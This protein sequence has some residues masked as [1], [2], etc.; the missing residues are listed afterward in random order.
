MASITAVIGANTTVSANVLSNTS[1]VVRSS[2]Q[3]LSAVVTA[4][5]VTT[6]K[7]T[8]EQDVVVTSYRIS[9]RTI[10]L[11]DISDVIANEPIDGSML[12]YN[13]STDCWE[14]RTIIDN[15][16][17]ELNGGHF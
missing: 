15:Q 9:N 3:N 17:L 10:S 11:A 14:A 6:A 13:A 2:T 5:A 4:N 1:A 16:N 8:P 12:V 7:V